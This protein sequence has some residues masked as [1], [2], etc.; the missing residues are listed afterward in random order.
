[1]EEEEEE[2]LIDGEG[3]VLAFTYP[4]MRYPAIM[5]MCYAPE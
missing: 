4:P 3:E 5:A 1:M 2:K